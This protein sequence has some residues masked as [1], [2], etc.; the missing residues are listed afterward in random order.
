MKRC[1]KRDNR[2]WVDDLACEAQRSSEFGNLR[3]LRGSQ[4]EQAHP[5]DQSKT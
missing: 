1:E 4:V 5:T 2:N 3:N